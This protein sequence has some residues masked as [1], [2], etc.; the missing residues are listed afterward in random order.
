MTE[1]KLMEHEFVNWSEQRMICVKCG[2][3][4]FK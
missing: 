1:C 3:K 4:A 2:V